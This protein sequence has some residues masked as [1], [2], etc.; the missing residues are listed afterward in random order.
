MKS[1]GDNNSIS[2]DE[3]LLLKL[4][5]GSEGVRELLGNNK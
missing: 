2:L 1:T 3:L 4:Q 5:Y